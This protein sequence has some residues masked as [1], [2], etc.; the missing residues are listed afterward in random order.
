MATTFADFGY[1]KPKHLKDTYALNVSHFIDGSAF[2]GRES[3]SLSKTSNSATK[4]T[5]I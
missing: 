1:S 2:D 4:S 5:T 3:S